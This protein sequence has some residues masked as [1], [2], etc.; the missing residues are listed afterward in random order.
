[1][2]DLYIRTLCMLPFRCDRL[3][4]TI[5]ISTSI[6]FSHPEKKMQNRTRCRLA[7]FKS[8]MAISKGTFRLRIL[9]F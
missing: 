5:L 2:E 7:R 4:L 6:G 3:R 9:D 8:G 1:M